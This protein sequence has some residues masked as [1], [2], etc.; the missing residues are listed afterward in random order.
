M[1]ALGPSN[2]ERAGCAIADDFDAG[3]S[4]VVDHTLVLVPEDEVRGHAALSQ[5]ARQLQRTPALDVLLRAAVD[6][7]VRLC[8]YLTISVEIKCKEKLNAR[9][10]HH[11]YIKYLIHQISCQ[12]QI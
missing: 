11:R 6:F 10:I 8:I 7:S 3:R 4:L 2:D 1:D 12:L 5:V 9:V